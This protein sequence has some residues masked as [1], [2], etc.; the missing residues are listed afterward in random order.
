MQITLPGHQLRPIPIEPIQTLPATTVA[1]AA[2]KAEYLQVIT[3][4]QAV[5]AET[6]YTL[7]WTANINIVHI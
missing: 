2:P 6:Q 5:L 1:V 7:R 3:T 4:T